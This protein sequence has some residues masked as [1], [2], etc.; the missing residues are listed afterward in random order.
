[1]F[2]YKT[3]DR[4]ELFYTSV[5]QIIL[6]FSSC[7]MLK[8]KYRQLKDLSDQRSKWWIV[9]ESPEWSA[10]IFIILWNDRK[11]STKATKRTTVALSS[12]AIWDETTWK[13]P[14][15]YVSPNFQNLR[16][17][18]RVASEYSSTPWQGNDSR[19]FVSRGRGRWDEV[20]S[21]PF[22]SSHPVDQRNLEYR[23]AARSNKALEQTIRLPPQM[24]PVSYFTG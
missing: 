18:N 12:L 9:K 24:L 19:G 8:K 1:M 4:Y 21:R 2:Q 22:P 10:T 17:P 15:I 7:T 13:R 20:R 11:T 6:Y 3:N 14:D 5:S 23:V 16:A